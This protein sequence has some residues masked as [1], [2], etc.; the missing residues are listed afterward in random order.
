MAIAK[1]R[2]ILKM[3]RAMDG[4]WNGRLGAIAI[5]GILPSEEP[6]P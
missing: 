3:L 5:S 6:L 2:D 1:V 4:S